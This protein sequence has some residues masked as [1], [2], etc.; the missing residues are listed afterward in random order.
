MWFIFQNNV[1]SAFIAMVFGVFLGLMPVINALVNGAILGYVLALASAEAGY[2]VIFNLLPHGIFELPAIF[3][4]LG[5]GARW[6]MFVFSGKG[7]RKKEFSK[8]FYGSMKVFFTIVL[9]LLIIAAI[10]EGILI[11]LQS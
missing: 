2:G 5:L 4:S 7:N 10:I 9:P 3:I 1:S 6:G 8:R 11:A